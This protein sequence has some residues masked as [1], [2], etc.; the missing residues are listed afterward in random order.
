MLYYII[1]P[2]SRRKT[3]VE[4][5]GIFFARLAIMVYNMTYSYGQTFGANYYVGFYNRHPSCSLY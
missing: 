3:N 4:K 2:W 5:G 1:T